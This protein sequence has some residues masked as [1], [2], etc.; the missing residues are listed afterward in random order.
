M[1]IDKEAEWTSALVEHPRLKEIKATRY[2]VSVWFMERRR[3]G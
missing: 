3:N 1:S 2:D